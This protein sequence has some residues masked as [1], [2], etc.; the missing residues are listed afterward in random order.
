MLT[1]AHKLRSGARH[2]ASLLLSVALLSSCG[3]GGTEPQDRG[4]YRMTITGSVTDVAEGPAGFATAPDGWTLILL[5][6]GFLGDGWD[7][8]VQGVGPR[9]A[10]GAVIPVSAGDLE[11]PS[12]PGEATASLTR[13]R[14]D[15]FDFWVATAGEIRITRSSESRLSG[16]FELSA[17]SLLVDGSGP[18]TVRGTFDA[19]FM[20]DRP[21]ISF[22]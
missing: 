2:T 6:P 19:I 15:S 3:G 13:S 16:T 1:V 9:P 8:F 7:M 11:S 5:P 4:S 17:E 22:P 10:N 20:G 21:I 14:G 12:S 18:I